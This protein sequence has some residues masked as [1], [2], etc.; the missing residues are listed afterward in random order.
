[1]RTTS[2]RNGASFPQAIVA[3]LG[4]EDIG[5]R[6]SFWEVR[7]WL[8]SIPSKATIQKRNAI[9]QSTSTMSQATELFEILMRENAEM[10]LAFIRGS[11]RDTHAVDD[12]FQEAMVVAWRHTHAYRVPR[13]TDGA[14]FVENT[15]AEGLA[16]GQGSRR[17]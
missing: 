13:P 10:L 1:M 11:V 4:K 9:F 14:S 6:K 8:S 17:E 5:N 3:R 7:E 16:T 15:R 2:L 12:I